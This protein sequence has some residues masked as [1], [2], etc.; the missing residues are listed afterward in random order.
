M[1]LMNYST[2]NSI[3]TKGYCIFDQ[4]TDRP[5][6]LDTSELLRPEE[7]LKEKEAFRDYSKVTMKMIMVDHD[8]DGYI[9]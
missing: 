2:T 5:G 3:L 4:S 7:K 9:K 1:G 6:L 8:N